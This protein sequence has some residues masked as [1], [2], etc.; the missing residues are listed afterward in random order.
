MVRRV[1]SLVVIALVLLASLAYLKAYGQPLTSSRVVVEV[2]RDGAA[3]VTETYVLRNV[4]LGEVLLKLLYEPSPEVPIMVVD[5]DGAPLPYVQEDSMLVKVLVANTSFLN[6]TYVTQALTSK[7]GGVWVFKAKAPDELTVLLPQGSTVLYVSAVPDVVD[8]I[9]DKLLFT[10]K[11]VDE[12]EIQYILEIAVK[13][14]TPKPVNETQEQPAQKEQPKPSPTPPETEEKKEML[15]L[16]LPILVIVIVLIALVVA[17]VLSILVLRPRRSEYI[18]LRPEEEEVLRRLRSRGGEAF[19]HEIAKEMGLPKTTMW[20]L[21]RR[22]ESKGLIEIEKR[23]GMNYLRL[24]R[25][26]RWA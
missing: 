20:R 26:G 9:G 1:G 15:P 6:V 24:K 3:L 7:N 19:Q 18:S 16:P 14:V 5:Q 4:T 8:V 2:Y 21:V 10:F 12:V 11:G 23:Y 17:V 25:R 13:V 22:L